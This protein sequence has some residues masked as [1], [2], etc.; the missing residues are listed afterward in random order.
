MIKARKFMRPFPFEMHST[1]AQFYL[2]VYSN[3]LVWSQVYI[4]LCTHCRYYA[5]Q[6]DCRRCKNNVRKSS[7]NSRLHY[8]L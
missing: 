3:I 7:E 8:S 5:V 2:I 4:V 1:R 6:S